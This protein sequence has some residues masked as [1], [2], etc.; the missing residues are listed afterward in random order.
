MGKYDDII[1]LPHHISSERPQMS[2]YARAAQ[3][4][5]FAALTGY[6]DEI[7]ETARLTDCKAEI[8]EYVKQELNRKLLQIKEKIG[9]NPQVELTYYVPDQ[10]KSGG[11]YITKKFRIKKIDELQ[12]IIICEGETEIP[13]DDIYEINGE[14]EI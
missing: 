8:D 2:N 7:K 12:R 10:W 1:N 11:K 5:P 13:I 4:A 3:F 6:D 9:E 14:F